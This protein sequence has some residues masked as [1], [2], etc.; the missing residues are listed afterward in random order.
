MVATL[1]LVIAL[2]LGRFALLAD[3]VLTGTAGVIVAVAMTRARRAQPPTA[4]PV[5]E[6]EVVVTDALHPQAV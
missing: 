3:L 4:A 2:G 1:Q 5:V 6:A